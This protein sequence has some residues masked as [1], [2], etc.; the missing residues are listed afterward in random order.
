[1]DLR[2]AVDGFKNES[3]LERYYVVCTECGMRGPI[4]E[5][6]NFAVRAWNCLTPALR[7]KERKLKLG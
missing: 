3:D 5:T 4:K 2:V 1:M 7:Q 6:R